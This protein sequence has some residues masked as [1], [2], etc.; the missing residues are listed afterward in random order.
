MVSRTVVLS[1]DAR[2]ALER[3]AA[4]AAP[5]EMVGLLAGT[6]AF[7]VERFVPVAGAACT[8]DHFTMPAAVFAAAEAACRARGERWL[9]FAHS[10]PRG[11]T[12]LS[13][14]DRAF[15]WRDCLQLVVVPGGDGTTRIGA[16]WLTKDRVDTLAIGRAEAAPA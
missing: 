13:A 15:L 1:D 12:A 5:R 6:S 2:A 8:E 3:A 4:E 16:Y 9:G 7:A 10:H 14:A 11:S